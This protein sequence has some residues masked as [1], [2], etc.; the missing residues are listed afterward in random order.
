MI[1]CTSPYNF[2]V[3]KHNYIITYFTLF[4]ARD[5]SNA[6]SLELIFSELR[7]NTPSE[8]GCISYN[9]DQL[10][11]IAGADTRL[12]FGARQNKSDQKPFK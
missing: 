11:Y 8:P 7:R 5:K 9:K 12:Y 10:R 3:L 1:P 4:T 6:T 2:A